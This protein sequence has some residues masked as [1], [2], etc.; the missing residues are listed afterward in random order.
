VPTKQILVLL[1][2]VLLTIKDRKLDKDIVLGVT[3]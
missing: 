3:N 1:I 2:E